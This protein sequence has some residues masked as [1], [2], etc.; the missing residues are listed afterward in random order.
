MK[1]VL[2]FL[3][4]PL[5]LT[6]CY[7]KTEIDER[8]FCVALGID[9]NNNNYEMTFVNAKF[10]EK[11]E[12]N[13]I[14]TKGKTLLENIKET[15]LF[16][17]RKV[18]LG[19]TKTIVLGYELL[20][21]QKMYGRIL[22]EL[23]KNQDIN[24]KCIVVAV[25]KDAREAVT[26]L[27]EKDNSLFIWEYYKGNKNNFINTFKKDIESTMLNHKSKS[28]DLIPIVS[29]E[30]KNIIISDFV[31]RKQNGSSVII[32]DKEI[33]KG[34]L[35]LQKDI[36]EETI[37][38]ETSKGVKDVEIDKEKIDFNIQN[39]NGKI[40]C[41]VEIKINFQKGIDSDEIVKATAKEKIK[42]ETERAIEFLKEENCDTFNF[43]GELKKSGNY[44]EEEKSKIKNVNFNVMITW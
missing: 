4:I 41:D 21:D 43:I 18:Y 8:N 25:K 31:L 37:L 35:R 36:K 5:M 30:D 9:K 26:K 44:S 33:L 24:R 17:K 39:K 19:H 42:R 16:S 12:N 40:S 1:R 3:I 15:N 23:E 6:G 38:V 2:L 34:L 13:I 28:C 14:T 32:S 27:N 29:F 11:E 7:D 10:N 22:D 20:N